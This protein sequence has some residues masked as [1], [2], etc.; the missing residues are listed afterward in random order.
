LDAFLPTNGMIRDIQSNDETIINTLTKDNDYTNLPK[1]YSTKESQQN[2]KQ[3]DQSNVAVIEKPN[4]WDNGD[5]V[6]LQVSVYL[7]C[8][9]DIIQILVY[10]LL[11][12]AMLF[13]ISTV[14]AGNIL[15]RIL[16]R[17]I[18]TFIHT[19]KK[20]TLAEDWE[21]IETTNRTKDE[22]YQMEM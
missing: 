11:I 20:K 7:G 5:I 21:K 9:K 22:L 4:K 13:H 17:P 16:L 3:P 8:L 15:S 1:K 12:A 18:Q 10:V 19:M 2:I 14:I 6:T